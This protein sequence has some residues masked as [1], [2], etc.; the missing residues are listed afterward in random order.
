MQLGRALIVDTTIAILQLS[1]IVALYY[2]DAL[3][4]ALSFLVV[5][6]VYALTSFAWW[7]QQQVAFCINREQLIPH[8][9]KN[10][11]LGRWLAASQC[12]TIA[13]VQSLPWII[14]AF[15]GEAQTGIFSAC[16]TL[17]GLSAPLMVAVQNV[18]SPKAA[19]AY[20]EMKIPGLQRVV[21]K[22]TLILALG[23]GLL[24]F[25]LFVAGDQIISMSYG[26][27]YTGHQSLLV[28]LALGELVF[29]LGIGASSGLTVLERADLLFR[30]HLASIA[31]TLLLA[32]PL[33]GRFDLIGAALARLLGITVG[34]AFAIA[35]YRQLIIERNALLSA[36][37]NIPNNPATA[38]DDEPSDQALVSAALD[39]KV[40]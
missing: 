31:T 22:T 28:L 30:A 36:E 3:T 25:V 23:M 21:G 18:L 27:Q 40:E 5:T 32:I 9:I 20:A 8:F 4:A 33:V 16:A 2:F 37:T 35:S 24:P 6:C 34:T 7:L 14:A 11:T 10:W 1:A 29:A 17:V 12:M 38:A 26:S 15:L 13:A 19:T 39:G